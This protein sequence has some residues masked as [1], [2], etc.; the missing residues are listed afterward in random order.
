[1][2]TL[3]M[4]SETSGAYWQIW[5]QQAPVE[6]GTVHE[7]GSYVFEL[8]GDGVAADADLLIDEV[9]LEAL[10]SKPPA[11]VRWRWQ[12]GFHAGTV[13]AELRMPG[14]GP[15]RFEVI[16]DPDRRKLSRDD[17]D[18]MLRE[19][20]NDT[21]A[22]FSLSSFR[23]SVARGSGSRPP[24]LARLEF[25]RSRIDELEEAVAAIARRPRHALA[26]DEIILPYH[27]A[28]RAT[29]PDILR[30]LRSGRVLREADGVTGL[31]SSLHGF[32]P[33]RIR[34]RRRVSSLDLPEH[35]QMAACLQSWASWLG[36]AA[37]LLERNLPVDD[38]E[39]CNN[40]MSWSSRCRQLARRVGS[41]RASPLFAEAGDAE[42]RLTMSPVF[43]N[44]PLYGRF[45]RIWQD[46]E[47]GIAAVF[48][49]FLDLPLART[50]EL[51][52][53]W[54][55]L[56]LIH[57]AIAEFGSDSVNIGKLFST[58]TSGGVTVKAT[59]IT[60][61]TGS[62]WKISFQRQYREF[63]L[64]PEKRGSYSR[65]MIPDIV[66]T[67]EESGGDPGQ[68][69]VLDAKYRINEN[70]NDALSSIHMYRDALVGEMAGGETSGIVRAAYLLTPHVPLLQTGY[71]ETPLPGRLFH[72]LYRGA[73]RFGA[74][75]LKPGT[76]L[77]EIQSALRSII[78][79]AGA[80]A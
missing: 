54:C 10:R 2:A 49:D 62:G 77:P 13:Q 61:G 59:A 57:A 18:V 39:G 73:F 23:K 37:D 30:S 48:G 56:R 35:R 79:D 25:L 52:E 80:E 21:F 15:R 27:R 64:E 60:I 8:H 78:A 72:P 71:R 63:W 16:T 32:L 19:I 14:M 3:F 65:T 50:F 38:D 33:A 24:A 75:T 44:D 1:M 55:F 7:T 26:G 67:R 5:P 40:R 53:L 6:P 28:S 51:Y 34:T 45:Y 69:I 22:L 4:R 68:L 42:P 43:R 66:M 36:V 41:L 74:V 46:I 31:P 9:R 17:F 58:D 20:L 29:G 70:L 76:P 12:P 11:A 47:R